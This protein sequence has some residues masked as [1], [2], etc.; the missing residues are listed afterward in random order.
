MTD[1]L[2]YGVSIGLCLL[3]Y[4][5]V[6]LLIAAF[7]EHVN[8]MENA[9]GFIGGYRLHLTRGHHWADRIL[10][11]VSALGQR[12]RGHVAKKCARSRTVYLE[13]LYEANHPRLSAIRK[14][15][16]ARQ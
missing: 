5:V 10:R 4:G 13:Q 15:V 9:D 3:V 7:Q 11:Q 6:L 2:I 16:N 12:I 1:F 8:R 14:V